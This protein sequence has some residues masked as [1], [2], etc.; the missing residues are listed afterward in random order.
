MPIDL[1]RVRTEALEDNTAQGVFKHLRALESKREMVISRWVWELLQ[2]ARDVTPSDEKLTA[3]IQCTQEHLTFCHNGRPFTH[4]EVAHLIYYGSTKY[5]DPESLGQ[6]GSGFLT[7]HLLSPTVN[8]SGQ[9]EDEKV[10]DFELDRTGESVGDLQTNLNTS[11]HAFKS[12]L[13]PNP[14]GNKLTRFRYS[15][16]E[17]RMEAVRGGINTLARNGPYVM[18]FSPEFGKIRIKA[19][20]EERAIKLLDR[21]T[22][23]RHIEEVCIAVTG[24]D[25]METEICRFLVS[26]CDGVAIAVPFGYKDKSIC[27]KSIADVPRLFLGFP[28]IG[29][30]NFRF[31]AVIQCFHFK[32]TEDRDGV[33]LGIGENDENEDVVQRACGLVIEALRFAATSNWENACVLARVP[34]RHEYSWAS[35]DWLRNE[36]RTQ[37]I[38]PIRDAPVVVTEAGTV[39][40]PSNA[41]LPIADEPEGVERLWELA[42]DIAEIK[43]KLPRASEAKGWRE[44]ANSWADIHQCS[45]AELEE[46]IDGRKLALLAQAT[47]TLDGLRVC[48][49]DETK[50]AEWLNGLHHFLKNYGFAELLRSLCIVPDQ[51]GRFQELMQ[52]HRDRGI[53]EELKNI[54]M[55]L[56]WD[57]RKELR[58]SHFTAFDIEPGAGDRDCD[59]IL[60]ELTSILHDRMEEEV[61]DDS[62]KACV[63]LFAWMVE[64]NKWRF[65]RGYPTF[66]DE[67]E[68]ST[69]INLERHEEA[70]DERPLAPI[71]AWP[72]ELKQYADLFPRQHILAG[73]FAA[74]VDSN[75]W[76][77]LEDRRFLRRTVLYSRMAPLRDFLPDELLEDDDEDEVDHKVRN[78]VAVTD[79]AFLTKS[80]VGVMT[81]VPQSRARSALFWQ[82]ITQWL[83]KQDEQAFEERQSECAGCDKKHTYYPAAWLI[84]VLKNKWI[85]LEGRQ[86]SRL[87]ARSLARLIGQS[88]WPTNLLSDSRVVVLLSALRIRGPELSME[89]AA[90][91]NEHEA[92]DETLSTLFTGV[93]HDLNRLGELASDVRDD[94]QLFDHLAKRRERRDMARENHRIGGLVECLVRQGLE[95]EGF[96][97]QRTGTGSDFAIELENDDGL[98]LV[99]VKSTREDR[100][101][102]SEVQARTAVA[103]GNEY[104]LCVAP[105]SPDREDPDIEQVQECVRFV[106]GIGPRLEP[107]CTRLGMLE[108]QREDVIAEDVSGLRLEVDSGS[109]RFRVDSTVWD[110]GHRFEKLFAHLTAADAPH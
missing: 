9:V 65:F 41:T 59:E 100:V 105:L 45:P 3:T 83:I 104:L 16:N 39:I 73:E 13:A 32:P 98:W 33:Y 34:A 48:L 88:D 87:T 102:M 23:A 17:Q 57:L 66:S 96:N 110:N 28:L 109:P 18:V 74:V 50:P 55:L 4:K 90:G 6:F 92:L 84:P 107:L 12:S 64:N 108:Q 97:V 43:D 5:D 61:D 71:E 54:A 63:R 19:L 40:A 38:D 20:D 91:E 37:L 21:N 29:T 101:R 31:P 47:G 69:L 8:V 70:G 77:T 58:A 68:K 106:A 14:D 52:L 80:E 22:L 79:V 46:T 30:D 1:E 78:R 72:I 86:N 85:R 51:T 75:T 27:L 2:N 76:A 15:L 62:K 82:F 26:E 35:E 42:A 94:P 93:G 44:A 25:E 7:T 24:Q 95:H 103:R 49:A 11:W 53:P 67:G 81:R 36:L 60:S 56:D 89:I 99:E 10:F